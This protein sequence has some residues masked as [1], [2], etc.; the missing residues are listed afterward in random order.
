MSRS[1]TALWMS[2]VV[3]ES[4]GCSVSGP[5]F[6]GIGKSVDDVDDDDDADADDVDAE[7]EADD[8]VCD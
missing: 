4:A 5:R 8:D 7:A 1:L 3:N 6:H 2:V